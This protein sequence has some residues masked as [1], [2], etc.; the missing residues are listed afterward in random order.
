M[1][2]NSFS[3]KV[4]YETYACL[5]LESMKKLSELTNVEVRKLKF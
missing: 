4:T 5:A 1:T 2:K 3:A